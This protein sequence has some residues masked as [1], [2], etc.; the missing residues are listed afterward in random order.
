MPLE[1]PK[2]PVSAI[3]CAACIALNR[4]GAPAADHPREYAAVQERLTFTD[5]KIIDPVELDLVSAIIARQRF[6]QSAIVLCSFSCR[7]FRKD[8]S[9][10]RI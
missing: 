1:K 7:A 8:R 9:H 3:G 5:R 6:I 10:G 4:S 2:A